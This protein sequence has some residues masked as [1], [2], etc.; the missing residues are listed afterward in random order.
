MS[1]RPQTTLEIFRWMNREQ[2]TVFISVFLVLSLG[3]WGLIVRPKQKTVH[4]LEKEVSDKKLQ[5]IGT[6]EA[7]KHIK[8]MDAL[9]DERRQELL[10]ISVRTLKPGQEAS[11]I[12]IFTEASRSLPISILEVQPKSESPI[13][14]REPEEKKPWRKEG[15]YK[16]NLDVH[17][18]CRYQ[19]LGL[20]FDRLAESNLSFSV[21]QLSLATGE[22]L[23]PNLDI[24]LVLSTYVEGSAVNA[25]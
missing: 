11:V 12:E 6:E 24:H 9:L 3:L 13:S 19:T 8:N 22:G 17:L 4:K 1:V 20:L 23:A 5:H 14:E 16:S 15:Y 7:M 25:A 21:E 2:L 18:Q 10:E